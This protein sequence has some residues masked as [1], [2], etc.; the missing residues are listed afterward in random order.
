[1]PAFRRGRPVSPPGY[2]S[3]ATSRCCSAFRRTRVLS[4]PARCGRARP[5]ST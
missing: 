1:M 5:A 2:T 3:E 4:C